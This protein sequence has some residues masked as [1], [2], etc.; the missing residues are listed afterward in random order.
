[1][2][3]F[4]VGQVIVFPFPFSNLEQNKFR[5]ALLLASVGRGDW[6]V[7]QIT[8][9]AYSDKRAIEINNKDF[10]SG[11]LQRV[12]YARSGKLFTAH[13]SIFSGFAGQLST[14]KFLEIREAVIMLL[15]KGSDGE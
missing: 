9:N 13:E 5:P 2:G 7:C 10:V 15:R 6:L 4:A 14:E 3:T 8:S 12:S 1:V 11:S